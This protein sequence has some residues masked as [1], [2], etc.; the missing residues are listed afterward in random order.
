LLGPVAVNNVDT[1]RDNYS[2][3]TTRVNLNN[4]PAH[5]HNSSP[6]GP[7]T[8][9]SP[10]ECSTALA[11]GSAYPAIAESDVLHAISPLDGLPSRQ[12]DRPFEGSEHGSMHV[13]GSNGYQVSPGQTFSIGGLQIYTD[14]ISMP[15]E[16]SQQARLFKHYIDALSSLV[17][18]KSLFS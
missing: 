18:A 8:L 6:S 4:V 16:D 14:R 5:D 1:F 3:S 15:F 13:S 10:A 11:F 17:S 7:A 12:E 9:W 2:S